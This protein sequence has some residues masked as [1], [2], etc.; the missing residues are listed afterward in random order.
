MFGLV[1]QVEKSCL[2]VVGA[3]QVLWLAVQGEHCLMVSYYRQ[4]A[5]AHQ[6]CDWSH[7]P[8]ATS[9][10]AAVVVGQRST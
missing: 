9:A 10:A 7:R 3:V 5:G 1:E 8:A 4:M 2:E 6:T